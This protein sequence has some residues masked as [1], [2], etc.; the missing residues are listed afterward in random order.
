MLIFP[1]TRLVGSKVDALFGINPQYLPRI[2]ILAAAA[3]AL[4]PWWLLTVLTQ[5]V[6]TRWFGQSRQD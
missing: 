6:F 5:K 3:I 1:L 4:A 2:V